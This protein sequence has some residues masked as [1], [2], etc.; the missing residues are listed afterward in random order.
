MIRGFLESALIVSFFQVVYLVF[1][2]CGFSEAVSKQLMWQHQ[3]GREDPINGL[4]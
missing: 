2:R 3:I 4:S 1:Y